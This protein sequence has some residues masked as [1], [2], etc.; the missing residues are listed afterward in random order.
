MRFSRSVLL[1]LS[2]ILKLYKTILGNFFGT[3]SVRASV[4]PH[5]GSTKQP[6]AV[7]AAADVNLRNLRLS[8]RLRD[9]SSFEFVFL[10]I[11]VFNF[12][13][14]HYKPETNKF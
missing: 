10:F 5:P 12:L 13:Y 14:F 1:V 9:K 4:L 8:K 2:N 7:P 6:I 3:Q 11:M